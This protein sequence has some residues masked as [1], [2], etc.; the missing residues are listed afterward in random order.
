M[1]R[2]NGYISDELL[3]TFRIEDIIGILTDDEYYT[4]SEWKLFHDEVKDI[5]FNFVNE[6]SDLFRLENDILLGDTYEFSNVV[7]YERKGDKLDIY[8]PDTFHDYLGYG[9]NETLYGVYA[10][11][12]YPS[13]KSPHKP[14]VYMIF[15]IYNYRDEY[16]QV[17]VRFSCYYSID[18]YKCFCGNLMECFKHDKFVNNPNLNKEELDEIIRETTRLADKLYSYFKQSCE[19]VLKWFV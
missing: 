17:E 5:M 9:D 19:L 16:G 1:R 13:D 8:Y 15:E 3:Y 6:L 7:E 18:L 4:E 2:N 10:F 12:L 14:Y 11:L